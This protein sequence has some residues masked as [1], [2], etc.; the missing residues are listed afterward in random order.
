[1][2]CRMVTKAGVR[3]RRTA[4]EGGLGFC[5]QHIPV[6]SP[7][8][9]EKWKTRLERVALLLSATEVV[10]QNRCLCLFDGHLVARSKTSAPVS[11]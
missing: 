4:A 10:I 2:Q 5:W 3:C 8:K 11:F 1:M 9:R 7:D 6:D